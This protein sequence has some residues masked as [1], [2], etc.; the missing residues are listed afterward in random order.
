M[1]KG[2]TKVKNALFR[3]DNATENTYLDSNITV[4]LINKVLQYQPN[5]KEIF[6]IGQ[7]S[8]EVLLYTKKINKY[9]ISFSYTEG[10]SLLRYDSILNGDI[11]VYEGDIVFVNNSQGN[12]FRLDTAV[13]NKLIAKH[14]LCRI[15]RTLSNIEVYKVVNEI[16]VPCER[17]E[18]MVLNVIF[19][20]NTS[21]PMAHLLDTKKKVI[22][23][24]T[25]QTGD[26]DESFMP[27]DWTVEVSNDKMNWYLMDNVTNQTN[28][29]SNELRSYEVS[30][31]GEYKYF[32]LN[33]TNGINK[34]RIKIRVKYYV[35]FDG[36]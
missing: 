35:E 19:D 4:E 23:K 2:I 1:S 5:E 6:I 15:E 26:D 14:R 34:N 9:P 13:L 18:I 29:K 33:F 32:M 30:N 25:L 12:F 7:D 3:G 10:R 31:P 28:W 22:Y 24:Y 16:N 11:P 8:T 36:K 27:T 21:Y 20:E 17:F